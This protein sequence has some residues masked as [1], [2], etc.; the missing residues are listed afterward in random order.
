MIKEKK[1]YGKRVILDIKEDN[2]FI[3]TGSLFSLKG[4]QL[5]SLLYL[6]GLVSLSYIASTFS[7]MFGFVFLACSISMTLLII[8][9][10]L[11]SF[12]KYKYPDYIILIRGT[13]KVK[14]K[15][16]LD[17]ELLHLK[18]IEKG[19]TE[20]ELI[21]FMHNKLDEISQEFL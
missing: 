20:K 7:L 19:G 1:I 4:T 13:K 5:I 8:N 3:P 17:H 16:I 11:F 9:S 14:S 15:F 6:L 12:F 2:K 21:N 18:I 10:K